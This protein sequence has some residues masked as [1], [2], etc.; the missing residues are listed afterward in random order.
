M[1]RS[2]LAGNGASAGDKNVSS[3]EIAIW[4]A[5]LGVYFSYALLSVFY[6]AVYRRPQVLSI[7]VTIAMSFG[8]IFLASGVGQVVFPQLSQQTSAAMLLV[9]FPMGASISTFG[10]RSFL[11]A[12]YRD[13]VIDY[14]TSGAALVAA[15]SIFAVLWR[16]SPEA[17]EIQAIVVILVS[18]VSLWLT[19]RAW[20]SGDP[21]ALPML[22]ACVVLVFAISGLYATALQMPIMTP[23][24]QAFAAFLCVVYVVIGFQVLRRRHANKVRMMRR[25]AMSSDKDLL[26]QLWTGAALVRKIDEAIV[27]AKRQRKELTV[28][29]IDFSNALSAKQIHGAQGLEQVIYTMAM[30]INHLCSN[31][32]VGRYGNHGFVV[33]LE[34]A[35]NLRFL[36]S[37]GLR[38]AVNLRRPYAIDP[39][40]DGDLFSAE[41]GIGI[42]RLPSNWGGKASPSGNNT[43]M[44]QYDSLSVAQDILHDA[45]ELALSAKQFRSRVAIVDDSTKAI[46]AL[47]KITFR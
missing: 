25:L 1:A 33:V 29:A 10:L 12:E 42:A 20:L 14:G 26:T 16:E 23:G 41:L 27:R 47:E 9:I 37:L 6:A 4:S 34:S 22:L 46:I 31:D 7:A 11:R 40:S 35:R 19:A 45:F 17:M 15:L 36:R 43:E 5:C 18:M 44:G 39:D 8:A 21:Y 38:M 24:M 32:L 3:I 13:R 30:R 2:G 28:L